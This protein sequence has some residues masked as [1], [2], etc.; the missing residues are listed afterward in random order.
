MLEQL[1]SAA[2]SSLTSAVGIFERIM[3]LE[4]KELLFLQGDSQ[5]SRAM[6]LADI[7]RNGSGMKEGE[8]YPLAGCSVTIQPQG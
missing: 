5:V 1:E 3:F 6:L 7:T 2:S 4:G 8:D